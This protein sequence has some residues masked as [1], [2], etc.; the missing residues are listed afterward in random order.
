[1]L[2]L[3]AYLFDITSRYT[4]IPGVI[5]LIGLG[6][7]IQVLVSTTGIKIPDMQPLLPVIGTVGLVLIVMEASMDLK[8]GRNKL[9]LIIK[10][11]SAAIFLFAFFAAIMTF[12]M[13]KF[14]GYHF[15]ESLLNSIPFGII[16]SAV[17]IS[18]ANLA[19]DD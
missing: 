8:L 6:I 3:L 9:G 14:L 1:M 15:T 2:I 5:L 7:V 17:A 19:Y 16:S 12:I 4:K 10:S 11:A 13:V 18:S